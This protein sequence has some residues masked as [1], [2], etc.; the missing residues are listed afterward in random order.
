M[1]IELKKPRINQEEEY[2]YKL[3]NQFKEATGY[4]KEISIIE[5]EEYE[6]WLKEEYENWIK[7]RRRIAEDYLMLLA[8]MEVEFNHKMT[9]EIGKGVYDTAVDKLDTTI[10][11]PYTEGLTNPRTIGA[12][13]VIKP[14]D[15][16]NQSTLIPK[17]DSIMTQNPYSDLEIKNWEK[18]FNEESIKVTL[19]IYGNIYDKDKYTKIRQLE[20]FRK[21]LTVDYKVDNYTFNDEYGYAITS[22]PSI[23]KRI[24][25]KSITIPSNNE[26]SD[27]LTI[28]HH[29]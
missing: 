9:A 4:N 25:T 29:R 21:R 13:L 7:E 26:I 18:L 5:L 16:S 12:R 3:T 1:R 27:S 20:E 2:F 23:R 17:I 28:S 14:E 8:S 24:K 19:G 22:S 11:T 15:N 6:I 10:I